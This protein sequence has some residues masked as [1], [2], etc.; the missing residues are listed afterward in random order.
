MVTWWTIIAL[1]VM[2]LLAFG[3]LFIQR[4]AYPWWLSIQRRSVEESK[5]FTDA[6]NNM[7]ETYK[8]EYVRLDTSIDISKDD[9]DLVDA[10]QAQ[11]KAIVY[12]MCLQIST[13]K[14]D[15]VNPQTLR[16][17]SSQGGCE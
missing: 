17:L 2:A 5:S 6:N 4:Y 9:A 1:V 3:G 15:T 11:Q 7:L 16:W 10:Y 8:L 13:M 14:R 12:K